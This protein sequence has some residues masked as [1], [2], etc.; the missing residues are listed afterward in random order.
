MIGEMKIVRTR[1]KI[2]QKSLVY[3]VFLVDATM[4]KGHENLHQSMHLQV[5]HEF[6]WKKKSNMYRF[7]LCR[8][9]NTSM[10]VK[11]SY[12]ISPIVVI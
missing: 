6:A 9:K 4:E 8:H 12:L 1:I 7:V 2:G 3:D 10:Y 5:V 11:R